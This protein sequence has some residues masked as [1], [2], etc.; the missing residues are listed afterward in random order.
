MS[1]RYSHNNRNQHQQR[2][3]GSSSGSSNDPQTYSKFVPKHQNPN[4]N[5]TLSNYLR[6]S[7]SQQSDVP[8]S[9]DGGG[10]NFVK[11]LPQD[12]AV[13][14]GLGANEGGLDPIESQRVVDLLNRQ[15][16]W[17]L[18]L[19]PREF[20]REVAGDNSLHEFVESFLKYR[21]RWYDF[22]HRGAKGIVAGVIVGDLDLAR[23]V[24]ML[25]YRIS[26]NRDPGARTV[27][28]LSSKDHAVLLQERKLLDLPMLLDICAIYGHENEELTK[29]LV[30][31][32]LRAQPGIHD[33]LFAVT[34]HFLGIIDTMHQRCISSLEVLFSSG[35]GEGQELRQLSLDF[36]EVMDFIN[37]AIVSMD[38]F[39]N[40]YKLAAVAFACPIEL[41]DGNKEMLTTLAKLHDTL[42]PSLQQGFQII[43]MGR[44]DEMLSNATVSLK[45][46]SARI[47]KFGWK[48]LDACY[49][50]KELH[51]NCFPTPAVAKMFPAKVEDPVIRADILIQTLREI[52]GS[53]PYDLGNATGQM[54]LQNL[55][56]NYHLMDILHNL[57]NDGWILIDDEQNQY[58]SRL[59][60]YS[61]KSNIK[62]HHVGPAPVVDKSM[63]MDENAAIVESKI[64]QIRDLFPDYGK[65]FLAACLEVYNQNPEDVIQRILEG[66]LHEDLSRLDTTLETMPTSKLGTTIGTKDK[67]KGK[68]IE[69]TSAAVHS[70][71]PIVAREKQT[72]HYSGDSGSNSSAV[73]RFVRKSSDMPDHYA[74]DNRDS[75]DLAK[76]AALVSLY[77]YEDEY[78]DSFDDLG[79]SVGDSGLEDHEIS[80]DR[81][82]SNLEKPL[83]TERENP[84]QSPS[85][86]KWGSRKK[87]QYYVKDGKNYSYKVAGSVA[88]ANSIEAS[89][90]TQAQGELIFGLGRGGN[91]P[92]GA[93][94]KLAE[95]QER[96]NQSDEPEKKE[97]DIAQNPRGRGRRGGRGKLREGQEEQDNQSDGSEMDGRGNA[98]NARGRG[99]RG[100]GNGHYRKDR[101]MSKHMAGLSSSRFS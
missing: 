91:I 29:S 47:V 45:I 58:L 10:G 21:N 37:D 72:L 34:S 74:L 22:P 28:S 55:D 42:F 5:P 46:L 60:N 98:G 70:A 2:S 67:G 12:E 65:G 71:D 84:T 68:L 97:R 15:L 75:K 49:L 35:S 51:E 19:S 38:A 17:L 92:L 11:Y 57:Q 59:M 27:D 80:S 99:R 25:L 24:F 81:I 44:D 1:R 36:L 79:L 52:S 64:S 93:V 62:E 85:D 66:T 26:S 41:S 30:Q 31:N 14:A 101:A 56:K 39:V 40:A 43:S 77:E 50:K 63:E 18:K 6:K 82:I 7:L 61:L 87:P 95:Y 89:L 23:R 94:N 69:S 54:F 48:L 20:W 88:V 4:T 16:S 13:A 8:A 100:R 86:G 53:S 96:E 73:G 78:D 83:G 76:T 33:N 90:V 3:G 32:A 9:G